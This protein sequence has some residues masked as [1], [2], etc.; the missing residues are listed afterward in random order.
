MANIYAPDFDELREQPGFRSRRA[1]IGRQTGSERIGLSL[2]ELPPGEAAYPYQ[3]SGVRRLGLPDKTTS[4][5]SSA[6]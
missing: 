5:S 2:W 1:R 4:S 3:P 6:R